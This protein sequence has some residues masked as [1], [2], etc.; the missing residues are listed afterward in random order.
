MSESTPELVALLGI[1][2]VVGLPI[3]WIVYRESQLSRK[4]YHHRTSWRREP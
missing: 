3:A 1:A 2:L 4:K